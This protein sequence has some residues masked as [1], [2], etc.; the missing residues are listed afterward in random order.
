MRRLKNQHASVQPK[1][2]LD[3]PVQQ[4]YDPAAIP[5]A[6][7]AVKGAFLKTE[8]DYGRKTRMR[9]VV[10]VVPLRSL[11]AVSSRT[12]GS[13]L[14]G[15]SMVRTKT[16]QSKLRRVKVVKRKRR[17]DGSAGR[18]P[19]PA[20]RDDDGWTTVVDEGTLLYAKGQPDK[21]FLAEEG[22]EKEKVESAVNMIADDKAFVEGDK[23]FH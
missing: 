8:D 11:S 9:T 18:L 7:E 5:A 21:R 2:R 6:A 1:R 4:D 17:P 22:S 19:I 3:Q 10:R 13:D 16:T 23:L 20:N 15:H 12:D 14:S